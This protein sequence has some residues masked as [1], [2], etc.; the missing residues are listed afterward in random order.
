MRCDKFFDQLLT[1]K[2]SPIHPVRDQ[3]Q[4]GNTARG[5]SNRINNLEGA[6]RRLKVKA[7]GSAGDQN[8]V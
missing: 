8:Q 5:D 2:C 3:D 7:R 1:F 4:A 6:Y